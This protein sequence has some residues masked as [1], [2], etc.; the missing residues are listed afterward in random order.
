ME[1]DFLQNCNVTKRNG[2]IS[3]ERYRPN[4]Y[5]YSEQTARDTPTVKSKYATTTEEHATL[6]FLITLLPSLAAPHG[7]PKQATFGSFKR[8]V[9]TKFLGGELIETAGQIFQRQY[10]RVLATV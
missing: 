7:R 3:T 10:S 1:E 4:S 2:P 9:L 5:I 8:P 6:F